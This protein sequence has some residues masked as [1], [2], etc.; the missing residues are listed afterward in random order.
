[1]SNVKQRCQLDDY[2][3]AASAHC[4][5]CNKNVCTKHFTQHIDAVKAQIDPLANEI[6]TMVENNKDKFVEHKKQQLETIMKIQSD[7]KQ[8]AEDNDATFE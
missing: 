8:L 1:M 2:N 5:C 3:C 4:F 7:V 6:N